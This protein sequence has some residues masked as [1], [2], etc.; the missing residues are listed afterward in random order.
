M[1]AR[2]E[3]L[4]A[5]SERSLVIPSA[6]IVYNPYGEAVYVIVEGTVQQR[7][8]KTGASR[9]DL[10]QV[11]SGL[12]VGDQIVTSGQ[13][14]LRNGSAVKI[15]NSAAPQANPAPKPVES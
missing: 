12:K 5:A 9:G 15:D 4:L 14:K 10:T 2:A 1:F 11:R 13:I 6:A 7:F 3:I 8:I